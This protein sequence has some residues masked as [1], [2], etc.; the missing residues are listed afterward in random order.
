MAKKKAHRKIKLSR[1]KIN[2]HV[3]M[4]IAALVFGTPLAL[5]VALQQTYLQNQASAPLYA[6]LNTAYDITK[7]TNSDGTMGPDTTQGN[8]S[9]TVLQKGYLSLNVANPGYD[10]AYPSQAY[11]SGGYYPTPT[12]AYYPSPTAKPYSNPCKTG[13]PYPAYQVKGVND[14]KSNNKGNNGPQDITALTLCIKKVEVHIAYL[15]KPGDK[16]EKPEDRWETLGITNPTVVD[17][18]ND[19]KTT[20]ASQLGLT[21]LA[22]GRYTQVRLYI[23]EAYAKLKDGD[24]VKLDIVGKNDT[25]KIVRTFTIEEGK[26]T[27]LTLDIDPAHSVIKNGKG[28]ILKPVVAKVVEE[29]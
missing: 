10:T 6:D 24:T 13:D 26:T 14:D 15:G 20:A 3:L 16:T 25:V 19:A 8:Y 5:G 9:N 1:G 7:T 29:H 11:P 21:E 18:L 28:Y 23:K 2:K 17:I 4:G 27:K 12:S 22:A